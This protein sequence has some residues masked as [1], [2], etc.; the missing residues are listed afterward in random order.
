MSQ[1]K[2]L[3]SHIRNGDYAHAGEE[4]AIEIAMQPIQKNTSQY[5]LDV[6]CGLGGTVDYLKKNGWGQLTGIDISHD[7]IDYA[8]K[9]YADN[10]FFYQDAT[11][12]NETLNHSQL[13][14]VIYS[15]NAFFCFNNQKNALIKMKNLSKKTA[16]LILFDYTCEGKYSDKN[17]FA[18]QSSSPSSAGKYFFPIDC[19]TISATLSSTGWQLVNIIDLTN[20]FKKWYQQLVAKMDNKKEEL[21][22]AF[23]VATFN[24]LYEGYITLLNLIEQKKLGGGVVYAVNE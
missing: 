12:L 5:L 24:E 20:H 7:L 16:Q 6:G 19:T 13:F 14:D 22:Q 21:I 15:F 3:L 18:K 11:D 8:Q 4:E 9:Q 17:P 1:R 10:H 2:L 23:D